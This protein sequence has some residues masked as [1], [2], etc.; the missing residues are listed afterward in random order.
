MPEKTF[1]LFRTNHN[2]QKIST[3]QGDNYITGCLMDYNYF[4]QHYKMIARD[5]S[6]QQEIYSDPKAIQQINFTRNL[7]N[8]ATPFSLLRRLK[9]QF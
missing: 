1:F 2:N 7:E 8:Q 6:K 9:K 4:K 3:G 5:L